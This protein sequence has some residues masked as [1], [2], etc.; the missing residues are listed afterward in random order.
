MVADGAL[1][2]E[3]G[4][5]GLMAA[6]GTAVE[7]RLGVLVDEETGAP[8]E[9]TPRTT[10]TG[11]FQARTAELTLGGFLSRPVLNEGRTRLKDTTATA[12]FFILEAYPLVWLTALVGTLSVILFFVTSSD[13]ASM[14]ADIIG[15]RG[16]PES[17]GG[18]AP[19][20]G[21]PGRCAGGGSPRCRRS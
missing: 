14:V 18:Y 11:R 17:P 19:F 15:T 7:V 3:D 16:K 2:E 4:E 8:Y 12:M 9:P 1:V 21:H 6:D 13:S 5:G 20:L 10:F